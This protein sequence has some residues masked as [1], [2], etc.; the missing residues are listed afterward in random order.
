[1]GK[2][3]PSAHDDKENLELE[4]LV[5]DENQAPNLQKNFKKRKT[6]QNITYQVLQNHM[7][8]EITPEKLKVESPW[9]KNNSSS[10]FDTIV[11]IK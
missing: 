6:R 9:I 7:C 3:D 2:R 10:I 11:N 1:M 4:E 8:K 5:A